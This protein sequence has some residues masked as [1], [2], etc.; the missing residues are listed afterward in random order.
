MAVRRLS[1][2]FLST[3]GRGKASSLIAGYG[4]GVDEMDLIARTTVGAGGTGA[5]T[6]SSIPQ[7][8]QHLHIRVTARS[9]E[10]GTPYSNLGVRINGDSTANYSRHLL[11]G[12]GT[13]A[14]AAGDTG[15]TSSSYFYMAGDT[16]TANAFG[17]ALFDVLDYAVSTKVRV[18]RGISGWDSNGSGFIALGSGALMS[19][20]A[21]VTSI[22]FLP[23]S[24][25]Y[26]QHSV[27]SLYGVVG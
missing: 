8:Y 2:S 7:T 27:L 9:A 4:F 1:Q 18:I 12:N 17:V 3:R 21:A 19:S 13:S 10:Q 22:T 16:A 15:N 24:S 6:F 25:S 14:I 26:R 20:T 5:V 23:S 11:Y